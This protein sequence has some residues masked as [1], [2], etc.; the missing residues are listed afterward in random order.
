MRLELLNAMRKAGRDL[1]KDFEATTENWDH[2]VEFDFTISLKPPGPT[3]RITTD[4]DI[5][6]YVNNGTRPHD[7][8]AGYYTGKSRHK[9]LAFPS[10]FTP[11]TRPGSLKS[12]RG[13]SGGPTVFTPYV[14]HPGTDA[15]NFTGQI[16]KKRRRWFQRRMEDAM[17]RARDKSGHARR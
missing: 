14:R 15:R 13:S 8:W 4:D 5:W 2:D 11:K 12:G 7:I 3:V 6:W 16:A 17:R 10:A 9:T 1:I